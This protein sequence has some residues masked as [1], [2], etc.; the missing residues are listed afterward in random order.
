MLINLH[1]LKTAGKSLEGIFYRNYKDKIFYLTKKQKNSEK[2]H[3]KDM[4]K[5]LDQ[6][7]IKNELKSKSVITG[8]MLFG[9]HKKLPEFKIKYYST[10]RDPYLR[11]KSYYFYIMQN[12]KFEITKVLKKNKIEF[13]KFCDFSKFSK[14]KIKKYGFSNRA[15]EEIRLI[16]NNG[17]T[18]LISGNYKLSEHKSYQLAKK[19]INKYFIS[20]GILEMYEQSIAILASK[21]KFKFPVFLNKVNTSNSSNF[22]LE[23]EDR[24]KTK[25]YTKNNYD[26]KLH[27]EYSLKIK[28]EINKR[29]I[30]YNSLLVINRINS[31]FQIIFRPFLKKI[32]V[33][34]YLK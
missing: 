7:F 18:R 6:K 8:H 15:I 29:L 11:A 28:K 22:K 20:V 17:Q 31:Y 19:N 12:N 4:Y 27:R 24:I 16:V 30:Y 33:K 3:I 32:I 23:N 34:L 26:L 14:K 9:A 10:L 1:Q 21:M 25:F 2:I 13:E 5:I